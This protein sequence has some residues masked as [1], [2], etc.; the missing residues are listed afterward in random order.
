MV[1]GTF[2]PL[3][4]G[5]MPKKKEEMLEGYTPYWLPCIK[6]IR[7]HMNHDEADHH[8]LLYKDREECEEIHG[9]A[10]HLR[11]TIEEL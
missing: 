6:K 9:A 2:K 10:K 8:F 5:A 7:T 11:I 4:G 3:T 1:D